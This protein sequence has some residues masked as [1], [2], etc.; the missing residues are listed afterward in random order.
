MKKVAVI[1]DGGF[2]RKVFQKY[3]KKKN[4]PTS[5]QII[6]LGQ[7]VLTPE[8]ELFRIYYYDC[9]PFE[10]DLRKPVSGV[11]FKDEVFIRSGKEYLAGIST[12]DHIAYR[13]GELKFG[14]WTLKTS[15]LNEIVS[16]KRAV[17][18][19]DFQPV[20]KQKRVDMKIGL[21]IAWLSIRKIVDR[22]LLVAGDSDFIP[23]MKL[24]RI[25]GVLITVVPLKNNITRDMREHADEVRDF[26]VAA[27]PW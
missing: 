15:K 17:A 5:D 26:D 12:Q 16:T 14:G 25:E 8:E 20:F 4:I 21:D 3:F 7:K 24:A 27:M 10:K 23:A 18:D 9:P 22:I 6:A 11:K 2:A 19:D 1:I 13:S